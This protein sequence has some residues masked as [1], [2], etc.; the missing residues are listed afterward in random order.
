[1]NGIF[2]ADIGIIG[3][4]DGPTAIFIAAG[5]SVWIWVGL[6]LLAAAAGYLIYRKKKH[7]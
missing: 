7:K 6:G 2:P 4:A 1:M 3:G 5:P